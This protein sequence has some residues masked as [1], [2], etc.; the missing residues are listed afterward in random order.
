[1]RRPQEPLDLEREIAD[2]GGGETG[3]GDGAR[4]VELIRDERQIDAELE[5]IEEREAADEIDAELAHDEL[6]GE[7]RRRGE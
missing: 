7:R 2:A 1:M 5:A 3:H 4:V 6:A